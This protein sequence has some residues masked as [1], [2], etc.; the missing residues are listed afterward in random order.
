MLHTVLAELG[1]R[2][3]GFQAAIEPTCG[4]FDERA[5]L[6][7]R[8]IL[9][10]RFKGPSKYLPAMLTLQRLSST[11][12]PSRVARLYGCVTLKDIGALVDISGFALSDQFPVRWSD[13]LARIAGYYSSRGKPVILLPQAFGPFG[14]QAHRQGKV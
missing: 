3:P 8:S 12:V 9:P 1:E 5:A 13:N 2:L 11:L 14:T 6:R 10:F 7:L 4:P